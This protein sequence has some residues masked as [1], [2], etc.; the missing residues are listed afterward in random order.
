[1]ALTLSCAGAAT[2]QSAYIVFL[3]SRSDIP[4][5]DLPPELNTQLSGTGAITTLDT[6]IDEW[7]TSTSQ[8]NPTHGTW[9]AAVTYGAGDTVASNR[10][11]IK[12]AAG[13]ILAPLTYR[14]LAPSNLN[15]LPENFDGWWTCV[16]QPPHALV[17]N[18]NYVACPFAYAL[19][20]LPTVAS[21]AATN[22]GGSLW[23]SLAW[24]APAGP[25]GDIVQMM[26]VYV[27]LNYLAGSTI[28]PVLSRPQTGA[29]TAP[30]SSGQILNAGINAQFQCWHT[31][32][33]A[34]FPGLTLSNWD[35]TAIINGAQPPGS[36]GTSYISVLTA[37]GGTPPY[38]YG[39]IAGHLPPG[40][41]LNPQ[42]GV[43]SGTV[44][45]AGIFTF[46]AQVTDSTGATAKATCAGPVNC[47][48]GP[49]SA[50]N[51]FY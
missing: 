50:G 7:G 19:S 9:N 13:T 44:T 3:L 8:P 22:W 20:P 17:N 32:G 1:V 34:S 15:H 26:D 29:A 46:T 38:T 40:V 51:K 6:N 5:G 28:V 10:Y 11:A 4:T 16:T 12:N 2:L 24:T 45:G 47:G 49:A 30:T 25:P 33:L 35:T 42:T 43:I 37:A 39:I 21:L 41:T 18:N 36:F 31:S 48:G 27:Q 23:H 14:S